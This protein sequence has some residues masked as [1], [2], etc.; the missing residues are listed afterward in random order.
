MNKFRH[1]ERTGVASLRLDSHRRNALFTSSEYA[2]RLLR[3]QNEH[4]AFLTEDEINTEILQACSR[5]FEKQVPAE[6][7]RFQYT[8]DVLEKS[9]ICTFSSIWPDDL[10]TVMHPFVS[11]FDLGTQWE[12]L[13]TAVRL[14]LA[15]QML[16]TALVA[17]EPE[18][19]L[20]Y[21]Y[22]KNIKAA[23]QSTETTREVIAA[24]IGS[25]PRQV[26]RHEKQEQRPQKGFQEIYAGWFSEI[27]GEKITEFDVMYRDLSSRFFARQ[28]RH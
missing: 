8:G 6:A 2:K 20:P 10:K 13:H 1:D 3:I 21:F 9:V 12:S 15:K 27:L 4:S 26:E 17:A 14:V 19:N 23:R 11:Q 25:E 5:F 16:K 18:D 28:K 24:K 22:G 7:E